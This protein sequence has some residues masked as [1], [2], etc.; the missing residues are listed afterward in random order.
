MKRPRLKISA[1]APSYFVGEKAGLRFIS[2]GCTLVDCA[3]GGGWAIGRV[4]NL[5]GD[6]STAKTALATEALANFLEQYPTG[7]A[8]YRDTEAAFDQE[9]ARAM[10]IPVEKIDFGDDKNPLLTVEDFARDFDKFLDTQI[11]ADKPGLY[12]LDSLDALSDEVEMEQEFGKATFGMAKAKLLST[13]F[14]KMARKIEQ[15]QVLLLIVSQV[16]DNIG[17]T[18]GEKHRRSGGKALDFYC[19][20]IVWLAAVK[21]LKRTINKVERPY[22]VNILAK[23]KKNKVGLPFRE[24]SFDFIFGFGAEDLTASIHWLMTVGRT[25]DVELSLAEA[26]SYYGK[27]SDMNDQEYAKEKATITPIVKRVWA[28]IETQFLPTRRKYQ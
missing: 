15:S 12:V 8:A 1:P 16:R 6:R 25:E 7:G 10:G 18:F 21:Q 28:E 19:S 17:V 24:A 3:L 13:L 11:K 5:V 14:R 26:K 2:S 4:A 27:I 9:Y 22:G 20:Q 23:V